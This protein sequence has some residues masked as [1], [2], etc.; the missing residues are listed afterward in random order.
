DR[1]R[2]QH[3]SIGAVAD[4]VNIRDRRLRVRIDYYRSLA[5]H[6]YSRFF[7]T[8]AAG[9][10]GAAG[11]IHDDV[12]ADHI[13]VIQVGA[14]AVG[15]LF[16]SRHRAMEAQ[17]NP[18][19]AH[20]APEYVAQIF[21]ESAQQLRTAMHQ[22]DVTAHAMKNA[23]KLDGNVAAADQGHALRPLLQKKRLVGSYGVV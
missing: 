2:R 12:S 13:A 14:Y 7:Q 15:G 20:L 18:A 22:G 21:I 4:R 3:D 16:D 23:R 8:E 19:F 6:H 17:I 9:V 10:R 1:N 5:I 11:R